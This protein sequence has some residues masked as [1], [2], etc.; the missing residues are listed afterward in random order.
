MTRDQAINLL[1]MGVA[2]VIYGAVFPVNR[3]AAE[4]GWP[5]MAYGAYQTLIAGA[6]LAA[7]VLLRGHRLVPTRR[8]PLSY[9]A[10]GSVAIAL[11]AGVL[12]MSA[13]HVPGSLLTLVMSLSP[14]LTLLFS[15]LLRLEAF[16]ARALLAVAMGFVGVLL[17]ASPWSQ[18]LD[19]REAPWFLLALLAP[20]MFAMSNVAASVLRPPATASV[21]MAAGILL[22]GGVVAFVAALAMDPGLWPR[23]ALPVAL[24]PLLAAS[25][26][27]AVVI[28]LFFEIVRRA[29][30]AFFSLFNF[31]TI[32]SGVLWSI[33]V[34]GESLPRA[35]FLAFAVMLAGV[36][37]AIGGQRAAPAGAG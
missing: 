34:F 10:I 18:A 37:I 16:R 25:A 36:A 30:P 15:I 17:I 4:A 20:T 2:G 28:V 31:V 21:T 1:M 24:P 7:I 29:G 8:H 13:G 32:P 23:T 33:A 3:A 6:L 22:G 14:I 9:V 19:A 26:V 27:N 5:P 11:P 35:F 12:T